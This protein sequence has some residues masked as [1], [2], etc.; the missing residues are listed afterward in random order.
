MAVTPH[1]DEAFLREVDEE[2]RR[3]QMVDV[4]TR[5]G[6]WIIGAVV[7]GL[8]VFAGVLGWRYWS[9][10]R[11]EGQAITLQTA[12][13]QLAAAKPDAAKAPLAELDASGGP[14]YRALARMSEGNELLK[15]GKV[16][17]A[18]AKYAAV[19]GDD[20]VGKP[21]R[22]LAL[23]R[24]TAIEFETLG[25][26]VVIDRL[27]PLA[28]RES[29]W[30]GSAGEMVALAYLKQGKPD[31]ARELFKLI[32]AGEDVPQTIRERAVQMVEAVDV[33]TA[34]AKDK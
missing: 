18:A 5:Y 16:K 31:Q 14:G 15:A 17:E 28:V 13:D 34:G 23:V 6:R 3:E 12:Y 32:G 29:A 33:G 8:V 4:W 10:S 26:Q 27:K 9:H 1:T 2:L 22:D 19:A 30:L 20:G 11:A 25:P 21:L 24:Q 7:A